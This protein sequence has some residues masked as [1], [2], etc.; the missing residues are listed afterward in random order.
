M[1]RSNV[2]L[3][4]LVLGGLAAFFIFNKK[5]AAK[6]PAPAPAGGGPYLVTL[7]P[8]AVSPA[9]VP[10]SMAPALG[11]VTAAAAIWSNL[12]PASGPALGSI[13]FPSGSQAAAIFLPFATDENS[14]LYT[15]WSG[16][17][18]IVNPS[19]DL[20]GNYAARLLGS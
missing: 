1:A 2:A 9:E 3:G 11:P 8:S 16:Q 6:S 10:A 18:Y 13:N 20:L 7:P 19:P 4:Y 12:T 17:I 5:A 15:M 14:N